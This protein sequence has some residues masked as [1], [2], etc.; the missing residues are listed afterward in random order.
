M[1]LLVDMNLAPDWAQFLSDAGFEAI[2]WSTLGQATASDTEIMTYA[3]TH[4]YVILTHDLDFGIILALTH[5]EKPSIVQIRSED[6]YPSVIGKLILSA[7][8]LGRADLESGA[9][10]TVDSK[11]TRLRLL[12]FPSE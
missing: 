12:P 9:L 8:V 1:K 3:S 2:H 5:R 11:R 7:L 10:I 4:G 6:L